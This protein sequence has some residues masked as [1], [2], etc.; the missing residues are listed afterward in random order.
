M[1]AAC[2]CEFDGNV[3]IT[4]NHVLAKLETVERYLNIE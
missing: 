4:P 2:E 3:P 1:A